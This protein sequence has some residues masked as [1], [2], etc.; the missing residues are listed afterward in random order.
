MQKKFISTEV[1][2]RE[3]I[4]GVKV[5]D[6]KRNFNQ[7]IGSALVKTI[8]RTKYLKI[9]WMCGSA[10]ESFK[11]DSYACSAR[12]SN[13]IVYARKKVFNPPARMDQLTKDK[14]VREVK[15]LFG[16]K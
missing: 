12:C 10:Y 7:T 3:N 6:E 13:N 15:E 14:N 8:R 16:Y 2:Y 5:E 9:C 11:Y 4:I 1:L